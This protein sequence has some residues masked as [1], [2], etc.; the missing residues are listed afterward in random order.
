MID[1]EAL[2]RV[3]ARLGRTPR[4]LDVAC[5]TGIL[6]RRLLEEL[7][8]VEA[9]GVD[10]ST[11]M[12]SQ[13][14][15]TLRPWP[16]ARLIQAVVGPEPTGCL[17]FAPGTFDLI[18]CTNTLHYFSSPAAALTCLGQL[19]AQDGQLVVEDFAR[20][21]PPFPWRAF[22]WLLRTVDASHVRAYTLAE[23]RALCQEAG[24]QIAGARTFPVDWLWQGWAARCAM[25]IHRSWAG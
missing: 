17:P 21:G 22:E 13:A 20:R 25:S 2:R 10:A 15:E 7:P 11:E 8:G 19:L 23:A 3:P 4:V 18:T 24:L 14:R 16:Q 6:L 12:L 9:F 1:V 5:G